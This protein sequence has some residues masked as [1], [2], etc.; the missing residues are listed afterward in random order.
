MAATGRR[1]VGVLLAE[2]RQALD[3][4]EEHLDRFSSVLDELEAE[5]ARQRGEQ[6]KRKG[7]GWL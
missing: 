1:D 5:T 2:T 4:F 6:G 7:H 3:I